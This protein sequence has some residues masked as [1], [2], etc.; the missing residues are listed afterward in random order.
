MSNGS[1][2][3]IHYFV[4]KRCK[5]FSRTS[6]IVVPT[7]H[8]LSIAIVGRSVYIINSQVPVAGPMYPLLFLD[9][10]ASTVRR[11]FRIY[12]NRGTTRLC[13][14]NSVGWNRGTD[15]LWR[16]GFNESK[17]S[18]RYYRPFIPREICFR[19]RVFSLCRRY[20]YRSECRGR[21]RTRR[22][23]PTP[24]TSESPIGFFYIGVV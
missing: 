1:R 17:T 7:F 20:M 19:F 2:A 8:I 15:L 24:A 23:S 9:H 14:Y 5:R 18:R 10:R 12:R 3:C 16:D 13:A 4:S 21:T 11:N 22:W 6:R